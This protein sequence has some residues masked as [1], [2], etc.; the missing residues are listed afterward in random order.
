ML[1]QLIEEVS[2]L[3]GWVTTQLGWEGSLGWFQIL[4]LAL[5]VVGALVVARNLIGGRSGGGGG[6]SQS[7]GYLPLSGTRGLPTSY[8]V[9]SKR[10]G[11]FGVDKGVYDF[12]VP[13]P[14]PNLSKLREP[15]KLDIEKASRLFMVP[16][17]TKPVIGPEARELPSQEKENV[18]GEIVP[19]SSGPD[20]DLARKLFVG[21]RP[22]LW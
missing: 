4:L 13:S 22:R 11:D 15:V 21:K 9:G 10:L 7:M 2:G 1:E 8:Y 16:N 19:K 6:Y 18:V 5:A 20:W 17:F 12:K 14:K 3:F